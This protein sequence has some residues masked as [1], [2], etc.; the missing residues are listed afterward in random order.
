MLKK[1][2][3]KKT[4]LLVAVLILLV[5]V[6]YFLLPKPPVTEDTTEDE[7]ALSGLKPLAG[8]LTEEAKYTKQ[9]V[10]NIPVE[11]ST[12][13]PTVVTAWEVN[14]HLSMVAKKT[15]QRLADSLLVAGLPTRLDANTLSWANLDYQIVFDQSQSVVWIYNL[16]PDDK[17]AAPTKEQA[18]ATV[19]NFLSQNKLLEPDLT[20]AADQAVPVY[21][22][23]EMLTT[24]PPP[25]TTP[26]AYFVP[27][28]RVLDYPCVYDFYSYPR[29][30]IIRGD[31]KIQLAKFQYL[32]L[33]T[34]SAAKVNLLPYQEV[35]KNQSNLK[36]QLELL[37]NTTAEV[38]YP[39]VITNV[40]VGYS[41]DS[42][43]LITPQYIFLGEAAAAT[44]T[45]VPFRLILPAT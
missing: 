9:V 23:P 39:L 30:F 24:S 21:V 8:E 43:G 22:A 12:N 44:G 31:L 7:N 4:A 45:K 32:P 6:V 40:S 34:D 13:L 33:E 3:P 18:L 38:T 2:N 36:D 41:E 5:L 37:V 17:M 28:V 16:Q 25:G 15:G 14:T 29:Y 11:V 26:N 1:L 42:T 35:L 20:I 10:E 19:N 27:V